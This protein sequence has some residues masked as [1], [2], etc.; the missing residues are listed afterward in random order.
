[1]K[2]FHLNETF[3][4]VSLKALQVW[5]VSSL[6]LILPTSLTPLIQK[7]NH[8]QGR[9]MSLLALNESTSHIKE[10]Y[11][12]RSNRLMTLKASLMINCSWCRRW[13]GPSRQPDRR[14]LKISKTS[15]SKPLFENLK[16]SGWDSQPIY[17][18]DRAG[19]WHG[20][21][22]K[23]LRTRDARVRKL[24]DL[25]WNLPVE[26]TRKNKLR[27]QQKTMSLLAKPEYHLSNH[28]SDTLV[29]HL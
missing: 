16:I 29:T 18:K 3:Q 9:M 11:K 23:I 13:S 28:I 25:N 4:S 5:I 15:A 17:W 24:R 8:G 20:R 27:T 22:V 6:K 10:N 26:S 12:L 2:R 1:M 21:F 19:G 7:L 14:V